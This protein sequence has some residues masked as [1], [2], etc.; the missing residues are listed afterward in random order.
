M[1]TKK[2]AVGTQGDVVV[3]RLAI[4]IVLV[5]GLLAVPAD[6]A[7]AGTVPTSISAGGAHSCAVTSDGKLYCWGDNQF[8]QV[9]DGSTS[10]RLTPTLVSI[11]GTVTK[12]SAGL[13]RTCVVSSATGYCWGDGQTTPSSS[14]SSVTDV[15]VGGEHVCW[16]TTSGSASCS[17]NNNFGQVI[18]DSSV[19]SVAAGLHHTCLAYTSGSVRC[20]GDNTKGQVA[21]GSGSVVSGISTAVKVAAGT[22][23]SCA[24]L[25]SGQVQC[26]G[27]NSKGQLGDG[28]VLSRTTPTS[29]PALTFATISAGA[30][31][32][33]GVATNG[34]PYCWGENGLGQLGDGSVGGIKTSPTPVT[35][36][37][38]GVQIS[39]GGLHSC[40]ISSPNRAH[41]WGANMDGQIGDG[42]A[43]PVR[44]TPQRALLFA[45]P[46]LISP[47]S[48]ATMAAGSPQ[49]FSVRA[50]ADAVYKAQIT[51][52]NSP[53]GTTAAVLTTGSTAPGADATATPSSAL[54]A[55]SYNWYAEWMEVDEATP[56]GWSP[57]S[58]TQG[59]S[60][61]A[62][63]ANQ[64]PGTPTANA[65]AN[66]ATFASGDPQVFTVTATDPEMN[67]YFGRVTLTP[68]GGGTSTTF[69]LAPTASGQPSTGKP[70]APFDPG[71][72]TWTARGCDLNGS[73]LCSAVPSA[74]R[75]FTVAAPVANRPPGTPTANA[76]ANGATFASGDPQVFTVTATDPDGDAYRGKVTV[77]PTNGDPAV[78]FDLA[79]TASGQQSSGTPTNAFAP[80][81]YNWTAK[82]CEVASGGLCSLIASAS[83]TFTVTPP[84]P[85]Q[86]PGTPTQISPADGHAFAGTA[87]QTFT[88]R[89]SDPELD[90]YTATVEISQAGT[91]V[92]TVTSASTVSGQNASVT[93][94]GPKLAP[95]SYTWRAKACQANEPAKC[96][97]WSSTRAF[98]VAAGNQPPGIPVLVSPADE[99]TF[100]EQEAQLFQV[101][102]TDP[103]GDSYVAKVRVR[104]TAAD[105]VPIEFTSASTASGATAQA[106]PPAPLQPGTY[107][108][109]A[110]ACVPASQ[111]VCGSP[112]TTRTFTVAGPTGNHP[113][114]Q[115]QI[116]SPAPGQ[117][118]E[119]GERQ[120]FVIKASDPDGDIYS[121]VIRFRRVVDDLLMP[122]SVTTS[123]AP[124]GVESRGVAGDPLPPGTYEMEVEMT[125]GGVG[126]AMMSPPSQTFGVAAAD[127]NPCGEVT[128]AVDGWFGETYLK[129]AHTV[130]DGTGYVCL[131]ASDGT[132]QVSGWLRG[133]P[134]QTENG[135][136]S[137]ATSAACPEPA[138][139]DDELLPDP[140]VDMGT[141]SP[142]DPTDHLLTW[143]RRSGT[144]LTMCV[145]LTLG[146]ADSGDV[147]DTSFTIAVPEGASLTDLNYV[148][149]PVGSWTTPAPRV[150]TAGLP[151][152]QCQDGDGVLTRVVNA[153]IAGQHL[154][155]HRLVDSDQQQHVCTRMDGAASGGFAVR[156]LDATGMTTIENARLP[157]DDPPCAVPRLFGNS[158]VIYRLGHSETD[159]DP[160][161]VCAYVGLDSVV[162]AFVST[163]IRVP[164]S[165]EGS[166]PVYTVDP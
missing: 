122:N 73:N 119:A 131:R 81:T 69:D 68:S 105:A 33:C 137:T 59:F 89:A 61:A 96:S 72:Y 106:S 158:P 47:T 25:S 41:C 128:P 76:P 12:V 52:L 100:A 140:L 56:T 9:G 31:H 139:G 126:G 115:V 74:A 78:T 138:E 108:W 5:F 71:T 65:P 117:V 129:L 110:L 154:W 130:S 13:T 104:S 93:V 11:S 50:P 114:E 49:L 150:A 75:T 70:N 77:T 101:T 32:T 55:G 66:N 109:D 45:P 98:T 120:D 147:I 42:F 36:L 102:A 83:R 63:A 51:V 116:L 133:E 91:P 7:S 28:T 58:P 123:P 103:E 2:M 132:Q 166:G 62:P 127:V 57:V 142:H 23:H 43:A 27:D 21:G 99:Y 136:P 18:S 1:N 15:S 60:V 10:D 92:R 161:A 141:G 146:T 8:G 107:R 4:A 121:A 35:G 39:A 82:A 149:E 112:S 44:S 152:S 26:W 153:D 37:T 84:P 24:L 118:F 145:K 144:T 85:N 124:S 14:A 67:A 54:P 157:N 29:V 151:S 163:V 135:G 30:G 79:P 22:Q 95:G 40:A 3:V 46:Q 162:D 53:S 155:L 113:Q 88:V 148:P 111:E 38:G 165:P 143:V 87:D 125:G 19:V 134:G 48:G 86:A 17:G 34:I 97:G 156:V 90:N 16:L 64:P 80:G 20:W 160:V 164:R 94:S 6:P 159:A